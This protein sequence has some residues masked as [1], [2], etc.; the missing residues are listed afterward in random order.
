[1]SE[2]KMKIHYSVESLPPHVKTIV[3]VGT[4]DGVHLGHV[5]ILNAM[6]QKALIGGGQTV[7]LSFDPHPKKVLFPDSEPLPQ[8]QSLEEKIACL[9]SCGIDHF[10]ILPFTI[11]MSRL[12]AEQ[13]VKMILVDGLKAHCVFMGYDHRFGKNR[14]GDIQLMRNLGE[15]HG[16]EV[17]QI[18]AFA[19]NNVAVSSTKIRTALHEGNVAV[20]NQ[21]LGRPFALGGEVI[22]GQQLGRTIGF[23]TANISI[24]GVD[25][26]IPMVGVY[27]ASTTIQGVRYSVALNI[28]YRPTINGSIGLHIEAHIIDFNSDIYGKHI[29][30][31]LHERIRD[32][33]KMNGLD[34]LKSQLLQDVQWVRDYFSA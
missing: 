11:E 18:E 19:P 23:P 16:F 10:V 13:Y 22:H 12:T 30:L 24:H 31:D 3:T 2:K 28:G 5:S 26:L 6:R 7:V 32:E 9:E 25:K 34:A 29:D 33:K 8:I 21:M 27:A 15:I 17:E 4:F 14:V 20:A 1:M